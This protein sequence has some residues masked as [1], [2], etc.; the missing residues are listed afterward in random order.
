MSSPRSQR[1]LEQRLIDRRSRLGCSASPSVAFCLSHAAYGFLLL[2]VA[3][4][5]EDNFSVL[6]GDP[7]VVT[8]DGSNARA[9]TLNQLFLNVEIIIAGMSAY[10]RMWDGIERIA[11]LFRLVLSAARAVTF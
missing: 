3:V 9:S 1:L 5:A 6:P 4:Q 2:S 10:G 11:G 7:T 8:G